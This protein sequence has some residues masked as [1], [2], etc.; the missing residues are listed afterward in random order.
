MER[1][2]EYREAAF[3]YLNSRLD[4]FTDQVDAFLDTALRNVSQL[5]LKPEGH[6][7]YNGILGM[8]PVM[9][10]RKLCLQLLLNRVSKVEELL[11][12]DYLVDTAIR[13]LNS[14]QA[15]PEN[16]N[17]Y[18]GLFILPEEK[19]PDE[20]YK[21][22]DQFT[23]SQ[24]GIDLIHSFESCV[25]TGYK[26]PGSRSGK[27]FTIGWGSTR[28]FGREVKLGETITQSQA[29]TQFEKDLAYFE[30]NVK[31]YVK[32]LITQNMYSAL[33]SFVYN[34]GVGAFINS[35]CLKRLNNKNYI[36]AA[37]ALQW[38]NKGGDGKVLAGLVRRRKAEA[39]LFLK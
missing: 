36:G 35:T 28:I 10:Q 3:S 32:V 39:N 37:E 20:L 2:Q 27:P 18:E 22:A 1:L 9:E 16:R 17:P 19:E 38:F 13:L 8:K 7:N 26:D 14:L 6:D 11:Q 21:L 24:S 4:Y 31:T 23:I 15:R 30:T 33:C 29:D 34:I 5:P 12:A 25:L